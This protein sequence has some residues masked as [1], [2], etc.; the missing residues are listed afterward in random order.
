MI[1]RGIANRRSLKSDFRNE[2]SPSRDFQA[3]PVNFVG[4]CF[5]HMF[6]RHHFSISLSL[7]ISIFYTLLLHVTRTF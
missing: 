3:L 5:D 1:I 6:L 2:G 4:R 7:V